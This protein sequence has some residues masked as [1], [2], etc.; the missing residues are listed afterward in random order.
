MFEYK[1]TFT[2]KADDKIT[3]VDIAEAWKRRG[4]FHPILDVEIL[5][6][7]I[8]QSKKVQITDIIKQEV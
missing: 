7:F 3:I 6:H 1:I 8:R 5:E 4:E 2:A